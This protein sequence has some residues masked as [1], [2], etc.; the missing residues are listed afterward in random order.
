MLFNS[1]QFLIFFIIVATTYFLIPHRYRWILL[2]V[3][4]YIFYMAWSPILI[5][6]LVFSTFVNYLAGIRIYIANKKRQFDLKKKYLIICMVINFGL[7]FIFKYLMFINDTI[8]NI[9]LSMGIGYPI[10]E[11]NIVLPMGISFYTFQASA[12]TIDVYRGTIKPLKHYGKFSLFI[13]FFPQLVAGPIE[14]S[15]NLIPQFFRRNY[16][17]FQ[18]TIMGLKI[19]LWGYFKKVVIA[20]R[21]AVAVNTIFNSCENYSGLYYVFA[22]ILFTFQIY[23]DFSG[24]SDIAIGSAKIMGFNLMRNFDRPFFSKRIK[25]FWRNWHISLSTW[26]TDYVYIPLG[27]NR[28][29]KLKHYRNLIVTFLLSGLWHGSAW[30]FVVWGGIHGLYLVIGDATLKFR[31]NIKKSLHIEKSIFVKLFEIILTFA[32]VSYA[33]MFFRAN[34][35]SDAIYITQR[36]LWNFRNWLEPQYLYEVITNMGLNIYELLIVVSAII[37]MLLSEGIF[38]RDMHINILKKSAVV[39]VLFYSL[40]AIFVFTAGV[41]YN[42]GEFIY[43]QF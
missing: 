27:G 3:A 13:S 38:G 23:C 25:E 17:N 12:Y 4:S 20:D 18:R 2:L 8:M 39:E 26:F 32:L 37:I 24:Y 16:P 30:T 31:E 1:F 41:Y 21:A 34:T 29:S 14:R 43:F 6:L 22:I 9:F 10:P 36:L 42:A 11:F 19:M 7:L 15:Q 28:V 33:F 5:I 40:I 35:M